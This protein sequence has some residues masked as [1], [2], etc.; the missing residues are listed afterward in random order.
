MFIIPHYHHPMNKATLLLTLIKSLE[1]EPLVLALILTSLP[2]LL[3]PVAL[4]CHWY[5]WHYH[6]HWHPPHFY[7]YCHHQLNQ[8]NCIRNHW[9]QHQHYHQVRCYCYQRNRLIGKIVILRQ[10]FTL[11]R[12]ILH[13]CQYQLK[14][15][16]Q[17][18]QSEK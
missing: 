11:I 12:T 8:Y 10:I 9:H 6:R 2:L 15:P 17:K 13:Q 5:H 7:C 18:E 16:N 14:Y 4:H 1:I 3:L